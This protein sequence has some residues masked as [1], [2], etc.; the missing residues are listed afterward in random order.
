MRDELDQTRKESPLV[1]AEDAILLDNSHMT[2]E[3]Q[4]HWLDEQF[5][6]VA[7]S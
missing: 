4:N 6:R 1:K 3:E 7:C 5:R 2:I